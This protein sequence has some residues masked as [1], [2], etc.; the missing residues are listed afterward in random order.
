M[1]NIGIHISKQEDNP[2]WVDVI[3]GFLPHNFFLECELVNI[4]QILQPIGGEFPSILQLGSNECHPGAMDIEP[5]NYGTFS[6][7]VSVK[8]WFEFDL[9]EFNLTNALR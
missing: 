7:Q 3:G 4:L 2:I 9:C 8:Y 5:N 6:R 1:W